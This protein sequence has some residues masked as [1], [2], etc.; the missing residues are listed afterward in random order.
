MPELSYGSH[1]FQD[2]VEAEILYVAA[3]EG[4]STLAL[5]EDA[6]KAENDLASFLAAFD[7][8][9]K[10]VYIRRYE[11][12]ELWEYYDISSERYL[13]VRRNG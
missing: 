1:I 2:L 3:F 9:E 6:F 13:L 10:V 12:P 11:H 7:N 8:L 5:R 4:S